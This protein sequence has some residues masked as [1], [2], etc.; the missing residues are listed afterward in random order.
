MQNIFP[1]KLDFHLT[2]KK[3]WSLWSGWEEKYDR[4]E[5][6]NVKSYKH[7]RRGARE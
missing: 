6:E 7:E 1:I 5:C 4:K 3:I 2:D